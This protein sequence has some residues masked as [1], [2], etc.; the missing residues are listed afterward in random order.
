[1]S[2]RTTS[3]R[4]KVL[5]V[6]DNL[7]TV[8]GLVRLLT[9]EGHQVEYAINGYVAL[10]IAR[11]FRPDVVVLDL[12]LPGL[13]GFHVCARLRAEPGFERTRF[14]AVTAYDHA[15]YRERSR[16]AGCELHIV[17]PYDPNF[18]LRIVGTGSA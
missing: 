11:Q 10:D 2:P 5:V 3:S 9:G 7:D 12:G 16:A 15:E 1:M 17:K 18:L 8:H 6:E 14:I 4:I 13:N